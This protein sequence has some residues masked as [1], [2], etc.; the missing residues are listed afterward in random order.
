MTAMHNPRYLIVAAVNRAALVVA[1]DPKLADGVW[2][3]LGA[4]FYD[5]E[6]REW[7]QA[8]ARTDVAAPRN[9]EVKLREEKRR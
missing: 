8:I 2:R 3:C 6:R 4:P 7:C 9:G 1:V 5:S